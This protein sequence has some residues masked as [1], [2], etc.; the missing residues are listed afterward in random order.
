MP[1]QDWTWPA[2]NHSRSYN[3]PSIREQ[4]SSRWLYIQSSPFSILIKQWCMVGEWWGKRAEIIVLLGV[5]SLTTLRPHWRSCLIERL[6]ALVTITV[7]LRRIVLSI[8]TCLWLSNDVWRF[9]GGFFCF[10][11]VQI[12]RINT[13]RERLFWNL[14]GGASISEEW[15][16]RFHYHDADR[17]TGGVEFEYKVTGVVAVRETETSWAS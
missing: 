1:L 5:P 4:R 11:D 14:K 2:I 6:A 17:W 3:Q 13:Q 12:R 7:Q 8:K 10:W 9:L 15:I 16:V